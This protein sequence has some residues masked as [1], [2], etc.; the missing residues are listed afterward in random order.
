M[1]KTL[2]NEKGDRVI[3]DDSLEQVFRGRGFVLT[4]DP[5]ISADAAAAAKAEADAAAAASGSGDSD[6]EE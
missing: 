3:V 2:W 4:S 5:T 1:S 6:D